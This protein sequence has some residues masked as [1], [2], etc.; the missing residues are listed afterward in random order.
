MIIDTHIHA[1]VDS[2]AERAMAKLAQTAQMKP[3]T[4]GT[5]KGARELLKNDNIDLGVL[6]PI[7]TKPAHQTTINNWAK[8]IY[9]GNII[10]FGTVHPYAEDA[11]NE[12]DRIK[13][14]GLKGVKL[15][16]DYQGVYVF[17][18]KLLP[19]FKRCAELDLPVTIHM[20]YDPV[21]PLVH[22]AMPQDLV[23][24][25]SKVPDVK[26]VAAHMGGIYA[27]DAAL[28]YLSG[29]RNIWLD[30]SFSDGNVA[31]E[32]ATELIK[33]HGADRVLFGSD[34]P[35]HS[36]RTEVNYV[37]ALP[38]SSADKQRIFADNAIELL[39]LSL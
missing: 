37:D 5:E 27:W 31:P 12:L 39:N 18:D 19:I 29:D 15:H 13:A 2:L 35:W 34:L 14:L 36:P 38:L 17:D 20:G 32:L 22:H 33:Q 9:G 28:K 7:A 30:T 26:L 8:E 11:L 3:V 24:I 23:Y 16:P 1:F 4:D 25:H 6:L 21:S 10:C